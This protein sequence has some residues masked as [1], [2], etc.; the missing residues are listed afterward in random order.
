MQPHGLG[1]RTETVG[2]TGRGFCPPPGELHKVDT[3]IVGAGELRSAIEVDDAIRGL[4]SK[5]W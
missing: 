1:R 3:L 4:G 5:T 2:I